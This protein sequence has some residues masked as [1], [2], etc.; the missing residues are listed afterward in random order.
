MIHNTY[1]LV[2]CKGN[3]IVRG[4][5][6]DAIREALLMDADLQPMGGVTVYLIRRNGK[7]IP[8]AMNDGPGVRIGTADD[9]WRD[10]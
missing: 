2:S 1:E 6:A 5:H 4:D 10:E 3:S 7:L 9:G 8:E